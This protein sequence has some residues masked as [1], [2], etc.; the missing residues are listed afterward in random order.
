MTQVAQSSD[1]AFDLEKLCMA[2][3]STQRPSRFVRYKNN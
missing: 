2:Y 1:E 3:V